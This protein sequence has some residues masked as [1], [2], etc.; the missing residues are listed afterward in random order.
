MYTR[1]RI[2][3]VNIVEIYIFQAQKARKF[4][5]YETKGNNIYSSY[6]D[7]HQYYKFIKLFPI[8]TALLECNLFC[9]VTDAMSCVMKLT[10][11]TCQCF[12]LR[13]SDWSIRL[14]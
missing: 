4:R 7:G 2:M 3:A 8:S 11:I 5:L 1:H 12:G 9:Y 14:I 13:P 10:P 6:C